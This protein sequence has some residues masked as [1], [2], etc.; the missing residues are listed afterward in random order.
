[1]A[2][3]ADHPRLLHLALDKGAVDVDLV[4]N[5]AIGVVKRRFQQ[6]QP[7]CVQQGSS[8]MVIVTQAA[9]TGMTARAA[10]DMC[11]SAQWRLA[12]GDRF[13]LGKQPVAALCQAHGETAVSAGPQFAFFGKLLV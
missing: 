13:S 5:L 4:I 8:E 6:A 10:V 1:M 11:V 7:V 3:A 12:A 9:A 2:I